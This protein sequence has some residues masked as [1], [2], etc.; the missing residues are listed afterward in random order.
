MGF[1]Y[2]FLPL[3]C[4]LGTQSILQTSTRFN[5]TLI[6]KLSQMHPSSLIS[7]E[8]KATSLLQVTQMLKVELAY[9]LQF[10]YFLEPRGPAY[11]LHY[12]GLSSSQ[13]W[14]HSGK[15]TMVSLLSRVS[16]PLSVTLMCHKFPTFDLNQT[17]F[18]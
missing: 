18:P 15:L 1:L 10:P 8:D 2:Y 4:F 5:Q 16:S 13:E 17:L 9:A 3:I 7:K 11:L 14:S 6:L 12:H